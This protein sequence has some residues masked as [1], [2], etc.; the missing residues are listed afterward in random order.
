MSEEAGRYRW[1][2]LCLVV[3]ANFLPTG[4]AWFYIVVMVTNVCQD[5]QRRARRIFEAVGRDLA[6]RVPVLDRRRR[7]RR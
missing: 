4:M 1:W 5:L 3:L 6:R 2:V 7:P